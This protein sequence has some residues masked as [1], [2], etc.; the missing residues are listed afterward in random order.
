MRQF[1]SSLKAK[2]RVSS[3]GEGRRV[4][5]IGDI[6]G[7]LEELEELLAWIESD[8]E[9]HEG[10]SDLVFLGDYIDRGPDSR[11]VLK[12]LAKEKLPGDAHHF[13]M[14]NHEAVLLDLVD[15]HASDGFSWLSYGGREMLESYGV[16]K[17]KILS[18]AGTIAKL[19]VETLP[20]SHLEFLRNLQ[21]MVTIDDYAFAHAGIRP[22]KS[23][24]KQKARDLMWIRDPFLSSKK[25]H[26]KV[27]VHG[28]TIEAEPADRANRIGL[29]TGCYAGGS[30]SAVR[31]EGSGRH[32]VS[33]PSRGPEW[34]R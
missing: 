4:Y 19:I 34:P 33:V 30:L 24:K 26:G 7:H 31:L 10:R 6:H 32:F 12:R 25:D 3:I 17:S 9:S 15:G 1:A 23:L 20:K 2:H 16:K 14:G 18:S 29:D 5:A 11:G 28:H 22:G 13:L 8:L 27:V 21:T